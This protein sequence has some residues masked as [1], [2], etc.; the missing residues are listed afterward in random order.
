MGSTSLCPDGTY[1]TPSQRFLQHKIIFPKVTK[2]AAIKP[3][4]QYQNSPQTSVQEETKETNGAPG[5]V[6]HTG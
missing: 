4:P 5:L 3:S 6:T 1:M 2:E